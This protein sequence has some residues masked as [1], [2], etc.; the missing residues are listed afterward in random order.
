MAINVGKL[1]RE[2]IENENDL[3]QKALEIF[4]GTLDDQGRI[5]VDGSVDG[6]ID[7]DGKIVF[8]HALKEFVVDGKL[9]IRFGKVTGNFYCVDIGLI[10]L[11]GCPYEVGGDF[12]CSFNQLTSLDGAPQTI[13][14]YFVCE[15]NQL[16]SLRGGPRQVDCFYMCY[17]NRL[18][19]LEGAPHSTGGFY[20]YDNQLTSLEGAPEE[21]DGEFDCSNNQLTSLDG[22]PKRVKHDFYCYDNPRM[23]SGKEIRS[24][25]DVGKRIFSKVPNNM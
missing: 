15:Y 13:G 1:I 12:S 22:C 10:S 19:S 16:T 2:S 4:N 9:A 20:C 8:G 3:V 6:K 17:N 23:F 24:I 14:G 7:I 5:A 18:T 21:V 11:E 25:C